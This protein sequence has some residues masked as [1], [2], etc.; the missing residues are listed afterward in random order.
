[1]FER[2]GMSL[3]L[4]EGLAENQQIPSQRK[5]FVASSIQ[6]GLNYGGMDVRVGVAAVAGGNHC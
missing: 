3:Q 1:M 5:G 6:N 2:L 4:N